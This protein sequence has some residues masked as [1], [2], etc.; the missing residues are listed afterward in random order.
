MAWSPKIYPATLEQLCV[1]A[2]K[3]GMSVERLVNHYL[4]MAV[5]HEQL[6]EKE[7]AINIL[8]TRA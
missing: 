8:L 7:T 6:M 5:V 3:K 1:M 4:Q 2:R